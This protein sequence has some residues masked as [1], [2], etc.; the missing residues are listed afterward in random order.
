[1]LTAKES[2][3]LGCIVYSA[4]NYVGQPFPIQLRECDRRI[5]EWERWHG[6]K[7]YDGSPAMPDMPSSLDPTKTN[8]EMLRALQAKVEKLAEL[9]PYTVNIA[10]FDAAKETILTWLKEHYP[11]QRYIAFDSTDS[12][13]WIFH[14][15]D[16]FEFP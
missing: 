9:N 4:Y 5:G 11:N 7:A 13:Y 3:W 10:Q 2:N 6:K 15:G 8:L 1:M 16:K 14:P 12:K